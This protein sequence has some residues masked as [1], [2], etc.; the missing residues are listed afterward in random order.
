VKFGISKELSKQ[1]RDNVLEKFRCGFGYKTNPH[2]AILNLVLEN[3]KTCKNLNS[4]KTVV[5]K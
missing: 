1:V 3:G 5:M 2:R 4:T